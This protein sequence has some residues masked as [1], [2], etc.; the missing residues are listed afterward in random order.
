LG[1]SPFEMTDVAPAG[2][3][4]AEITNNHNL[5]REGTVCFS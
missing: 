3:A 4:T 1:A 2:G 5:R